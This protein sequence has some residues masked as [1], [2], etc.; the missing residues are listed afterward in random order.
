MSAVTCILY[1]TARHFAC[2]RFLL[3]AERTAVMRLRQVG[4]SLF[5]KTADRLL[6]SLS[7]SLAHRS[8]GIS[9]VLYFILL[10]EMEQ[11]GLSYLKTHTLKNNKQTNKTGALTSSENVGK[12][13]VH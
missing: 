9:V 1:R 11:Y 3:V 4:V 7:L 8:E 10:Q 2:L 12:H 13:D 6:S 5:G